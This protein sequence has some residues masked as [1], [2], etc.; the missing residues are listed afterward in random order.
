MNDAKK[1]VRVRFGLSDLHKGEGAFLPDGRPNPLEDFK[2]HD[3]FERLIEAYAARFPSYVALDFL[4]RGDGTDFNPI[5]WRG[6]FRIVPTEEAALDEL[7]TSMRGHARYWDGLKRFLEGALNRTHTIIIGNHDL[8]LVWPRLQEE[9]R[10][11]LLPEDQWHRITFVYGVL[12]DGKVLNFHAY[13][14]DPL[15][16]NPPETDLFITGKTDRG[17]TASAVLAT[18]IGGLTAWNLLTGV[19]DLTWWR[20]AVVAAGLIGSF[21]LLGALFRKVE[22]WRKGP[23]HRILNMPYGTHLDTW[24]VSVLKPRFPWYG[25]TIDTQHYMLKPID[26]FRNWRYVALMMPLTIFHLLYHRFFRDLIDA[27]RKARLWTTLRLFMVMTKPPNIQKQLWKL[28]DR[29]PD[30]EVVIGGHFHPAAVH[31]LRRGD[32]QIVY[33][34]NGTGIEQIRLDLAEGGFFARILHHWK[35]RPKIA[36]ANLVLHAA[37]ASLPFGLNLMAGWKGGVVDFTVAALSLAMLLFRQAQALY[38]IKR[39]TVWTPA[40]TLTFQDGTQENRLLRF[41]PKAPEGTDPFSNFLY[42]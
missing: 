14:L 40:E 25:R 35:T 1:L 34:D 42:A 32:R 4:D 6:S 38:E 9:I 5:R 39:E 7:R 29:Y 30:V 41:D 12:I 8:P 36:F 21:I 20:F 33:I 10:R 19:R 13:E 23:D 26:L 11:R 15:N 31:T 17:P 27:R 2:D 37:I 16:A 24:L 3:G 22:F 18:L 28:L